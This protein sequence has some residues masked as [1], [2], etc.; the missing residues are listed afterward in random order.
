M[1]VTFQVF[2][3]TD[4]VFKVYLTDLE[5]NINLLEKN[6][7][8]NQIKTLKSWAFNWR[9]YLPVNTFPSVIDFILVS[10]LIY[11]ECIVQPLMSTICEMFDKYPEVST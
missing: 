5:S 10:D 11:H 4:N 7:N 8:L 2:F 9:E 1:L 6:I 3:P